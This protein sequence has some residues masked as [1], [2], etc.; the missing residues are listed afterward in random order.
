MQIRNL[1]FDFDIFRAADA[2]RVQRAVNTLQQ[3]A[4]ALP[5]DIS[6]GDVVR[7]N[8]AALDGFLAEILGE[9]YNDRLGV[10]VFNLRALKQLYLELLE[11]ITKEKEALAVP[12]ASASSPAAA[13]ADLK[14]RA[15]QAAKASGTALPSP[16]PAAPDFSQ[17]NRPQRRAYIK[18][19]TGRS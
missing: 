18:A 7:A 15:Q 16:L 19:L 14:V 8:C 12:T 17:M 11:A 3:T 1:E 10:D 5:K 9:D 6:L 4:A 2:D 13:K